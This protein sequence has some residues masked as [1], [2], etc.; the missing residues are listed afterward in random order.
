[1]QK[2]IDTVNTKQEHFVLNRLYSCFC[3]LS[4]NYTYSNKKISKNLKNFSLYDSGDCK[5]HVDFEYDNPLL[6]FVRFKKVSIKM[7][8]IRYFLEITGI[9]LKISCASVRKTWFFFVGADLENNWD[10]FRIFRFI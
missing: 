7:F 2:K 1:M 8:F 10:I 3:A 5:F 9:W 6:E 4:Y